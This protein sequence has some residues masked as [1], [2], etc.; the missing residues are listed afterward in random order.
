MNDFRPRAFSATDQ[1]QWRATRRP[2]DR[3]VTIRR[4]RFQH[5]LARFRVW[6]NTPI[7]II[8]E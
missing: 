3:I 7:L 5:F 2:Y 1:S 6:L 4:S 8:T